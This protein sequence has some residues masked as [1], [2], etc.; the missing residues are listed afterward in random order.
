MRR[1]Y[2]IKV[3]DGSAITWSVAVRAHRTEGVRRTGLFVPYAADVVAEELEPRI[4]TH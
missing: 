4:E 3:I 2:F 1:R